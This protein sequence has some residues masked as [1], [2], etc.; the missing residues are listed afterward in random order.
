MMME[1]DQYV[2]ESELSLRV[3]GE[4]DN[5][6]NVFQAR[7]LFCHISCLVLHVIINLYFAFLQINVSH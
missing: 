6:F 3:S 4:I 5:V 2:N 1:L 7:F